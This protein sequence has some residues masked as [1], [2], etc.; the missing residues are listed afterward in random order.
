[1]RRFFIFLF[2]V[3]AIFTWV[4]SGCFTPLAI[5]VLLAV[6][7]L[8]T[9]YINGIKGFKNNFCSIYVF[10]YLFCS[11]TIVLTFPDFFKVDVVYQSRFWLFVHIL[12]IIFFEKG[13]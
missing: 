13:K 12:Y 8:G 7:L 11:H 1:M 10:F 9:N 3:L 4:R 6:I 5:V 2:N